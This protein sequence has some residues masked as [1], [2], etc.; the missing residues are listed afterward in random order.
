[1][2]KRDLRIEYPP[3][4]NID[5]SRFAP[6]VDINNFL[7]SLKALQVS[8][9]WGNLKRGEGMTQYPDMP[10]L[11]VIPYIPLGLVVGSGHSKREGEDQSVALADEFG[12]LIY[13]DI[14]DP[15][16]MSDNYVRLDLTDPPN[17]HLFGFKVH[18]IVSI[19][20]FTYDGSGVH[21]KDKAN[22]LASA[23]ALNNMLM[24]G[25]IIANDDFNRMFNCM[26]FEDIFLKRLG[27][28]LVKNNYW[29]IILQKPF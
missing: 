2:E 13:S 11:N 12:K 14:V 27:F 17:V 21:F 24:P 6:D 9:P 18:A 8:C 4:L 25:G 29:G 19:G 26:R 5:R 3:T 23:M 10:D 16:L 1:M 22:E 20:V 15:Q 28:E 7:E